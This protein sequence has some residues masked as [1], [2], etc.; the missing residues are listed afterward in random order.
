MLLLALATPLVLL[1]T[2]LGMHAVERWLEKA[3]V[4]LSAEPVRPVAVVTLPLQATSPEDAQELEVGTPLI[5]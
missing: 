3:S 4:E 2:M 5:A 1:G